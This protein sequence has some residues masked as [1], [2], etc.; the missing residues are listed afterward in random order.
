M[1]A[2]ARSQLVRN[3]GCPTHTQ[4]R[5]KDKETSVSFGRRNRRGRFRHIRL[6]SFSLMNQS[7]SVLWM[8]QGNS[9]SAELR[10][11]VEPFWHGCKFFGW[12]RVART[13]HTSPRSRSVLTAAHAAIRS[14]VGTGGSVE[15]SPSTS[16]IT[17]KHSNRRFLKV[18]VMSM[19]M[20]I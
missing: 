16:N 4:R 18:A 12:P 9:S 17:V 6:T 7:M 13:N 1:I 10:R 5:S 2:S 14:V 15:I 19:A 20:G 11:L 3:L 8:R